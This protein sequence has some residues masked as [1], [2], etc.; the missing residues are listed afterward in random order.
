MFGID[1]SV[2]QGG[3]SPEKRLKSQSTMRESNKEYSDYDEDQSASCNDYE[4]EFRPEFEA[5]PAIR[6][7]H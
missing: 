6:G 1:L 5:L 2:F 7:I 4:Q 3:M